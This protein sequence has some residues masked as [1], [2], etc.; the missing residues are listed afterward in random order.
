LPFF[1]YYIALEKELQDDQEAAQVETA[2]HLYAKIGS[3]A[4]PKVFHRYV[5]P[6]LAGK[7]TA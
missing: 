7:I 1:I 3:E 2:L 4:V 5:V 6:A